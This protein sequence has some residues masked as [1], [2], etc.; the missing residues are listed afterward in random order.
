MA[1]ALWR[2]LPRVGMALLRGEI[3]SR[4]ARVLVHDTEHLPVHTARTVIRDLI[5]SAGEL[6]T[7]QLRARVRKRCFEAD[8]DEAQKLLAA[9]VERRR[10]ESRMTPA[11]TGDLFIF[12][13]PPDRVAAASRLINHM[14]RNLRAGGDQRTMDQ[15]RADVALDLL[16][17]ALLEGGGDRLGGVLMTTDLTSLAG[18]ENHAGELNGFGPVIADIARQTAAQQ[19]DAPWEFVVRDGDTGR[20]VATGTTQRRPNAAQSRFAK[21][22]LPVCIFPG[23]RMPAADSDLDHRVPWAEGRRTDATDLGPACRHDHVVRHTHG[24]S[25]EFLADGR[26]QWTTR[27]GHRYSPPRDPP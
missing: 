13:A 10:I 21:A 12:D 9:T 25:Y 24:W 2:R 8:P 7:G 19:R 15:L 27:L 20:I 6:T 14:A 11:G 23:C 1:D 18:L 3:C 4:R 5:T 16:N 17:G 26:V 22:R